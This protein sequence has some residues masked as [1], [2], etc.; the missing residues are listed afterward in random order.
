LRGTSAEEKKKK[1]EKKKRRFSL[2]A[3]APTYIGSPGRAEKV[4][5]ERMVAGE[6]SLSFEMNASCIAFSSPPSVIYEGGK[7]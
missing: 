5:S 4:G 2:R 7:Q 6:G 1:K 3:N